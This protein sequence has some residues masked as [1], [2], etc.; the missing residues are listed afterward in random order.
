MEDAA[1]DR[2][3]SGQGRANSIDLGSLTVQELTALIENA[4][5]MR[6]Q[7]Q[8]EAKAT[9]LAEFREKAAELGLSFDALLH[10]APQ[11]ARSRKIGGGGKV[12]IKYRGPKGEEWSGRGRPPQWVAE[13][14][15]QGR[16][17]EEFAV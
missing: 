13:A 10:S 17:R 12:P 7:K 6:R 2:G 16:K 5:T 3:K 4:E 9:L 11:H 8:E 1:A 15:K 14:E